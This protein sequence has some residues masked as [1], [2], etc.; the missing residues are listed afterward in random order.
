MR[1]GVL[2]QEGPPQEVYDRPRNLFVASFIGSPP[3]NLVQSQLERRDGEFV[4]LVG[5]QEVAI[6]SELVAARP[7]LDRHVG[8]MVGLGI[9]PEHVRE[10]DAFEHRLRGRLAATEALGSELLL[11]LELAAEPV[12]TEEVR[13]VAGD[14]DA[15]ALALLESEARER[16]TV[17]IGRFE[18]QTR[19][20]QGSEVEVSIN[21]QKLHF[22]D[23]ETG[24][25]IYA[26]G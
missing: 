8:R 25:G 13:E 23:L 16:R 24:L 26:D 7:A 15:A 2:Q 5:E 19:F 4:A 1:G 20:S 12:L 9:R 18:T 6:P 10:P 11:H 22:F 3:M 17:I 21:A 14:V